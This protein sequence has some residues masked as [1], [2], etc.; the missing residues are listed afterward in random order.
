[1][2]FLM[3]RRPPRSTRTDTLLPYT[4]RFR[5][6][7]YNSFNYIGQGRDR[8]TT[9][10]QTTTG[11]QIRAATPLTEF[12]SF[13]LRYGLSQDEVSLDKNTFYFDN[14]NAGVPECDPFLAG[15]YL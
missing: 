10:E 14:N 6:R 11:F 7:D 12:W 13:A 15:R 4:T 5:S 1:M 8:N 3:I 2:F 9:Y